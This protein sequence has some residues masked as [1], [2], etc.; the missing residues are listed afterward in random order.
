MKGKIGWFSKNRVLGR[1]ANS[2]ESDLQE[3]QET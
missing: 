1:S 3:N 2:T